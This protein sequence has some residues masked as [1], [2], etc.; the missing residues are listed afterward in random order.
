MNSPGIYL[1]GRRG[2][3]SC[4]QPLSLLFYFHLCSS[5]LASARTHSTGACFPAARWAA[6]LLGSWRLP[7]R[8]LDHSR[9]HE[10]RP[11]RSTH[12]FYLF[13]FATSSSTVSPHRR[14]SRTGSLHLEVTADYETRQCSPLQLQGAML[15]GL[16]MLMRT[17]RN[18]SAPM[19]CCLL[20]C[21][22]KMKPSHIRRLTSLCTV[23]D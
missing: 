23:L 3:N 7:A 5:S 20:K 13:A 14:T 22:H 17:W 4:L 8:V 19:I 2:S 1:R 10:C 12:L 18:Q 15:L 11:C 9:L 16:R 6:W 21:D